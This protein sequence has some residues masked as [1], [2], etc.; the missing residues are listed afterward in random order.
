[1][2]FDLFLEDA[3]LESTEDTETIAAC[4]DLRDMH[5]DASLVGDM[6]IA[7]LANLLIFPTDSE[8]FND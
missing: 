8:I 7:T 4:Y 3:F 6:A 5:I 1:M 2:F